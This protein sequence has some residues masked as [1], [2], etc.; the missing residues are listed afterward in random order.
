MTDHLLPL[1]KKTRSCIESD[2]NW[3]FRLSNSVRWTIWLMWWYTY[4]F[5]FLVGPRILER[6][7]IDPELSGQSWDTKTILSW[8][9]EV[10]CSG[11][12]D[13]CTNRLL[14]LWQQT[15]S[16]ASCLLGAEM[17][18]FIRCLKSCRECNRRTG[19]IDSHDR[20]LSIFCSRCRLTKM[21]RKK[22]AGK[23]S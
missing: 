6:V 5:A 9:T 17:V 20:N 15:E 19:S 3:L 16:V 4:R 18:N 12:L 13:Y 21:D 23:M 14:V 2:P 7:E 10:V 8:T 1:F 11:E 22:C